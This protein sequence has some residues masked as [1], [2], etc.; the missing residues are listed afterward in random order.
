VAAL[1]AQGQVDAAFAAIMIACSVQL[2]RDLERRLDD[3]D[4][5]GLEAGFVPLAERAASELPEAVM[6]RVADCRFVGQGYEVPVT[7][8]SSEPTLVAQVFRAAH[9]ARFGFAD[10]DAPVEVVNLRV[11]AERG[12][13]APDLRSA[14]AVPPSPPGRREIVLRGEVVTAEVRSLD[15]LPPGLSIAGP[16]VLAGG[17]ATALIEPGWLVTVHAAG[18]LVVE[19]R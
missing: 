19:R 8:L 18:A 14:P 17:D 9:H 10:D 13:P 16:A 11:I 15:A 5:A 12:A 3:L 1:L 2:R 7:V 6:R 4:A